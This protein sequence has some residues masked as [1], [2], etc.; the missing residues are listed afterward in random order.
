MIGSPADAVFRDRR[1]FC[2]TGSTVA[3]SASPRVDTASAD[4]IMASSAPTGTART[5]S[6]LAFESA[7]STNATAADAVNAS[8]GGVTL[9]V[10]RVEPAVEPTFLP[11]D[12]LA[13]GAPGTA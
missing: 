13:I 4:P 5:A 2:L 1:R 8:S 11:R 3:L 10:L 9:F 7:T 12:L 6:A